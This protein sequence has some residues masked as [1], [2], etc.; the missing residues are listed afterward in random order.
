MRNKLPDMGEGDDSAATEHPET[1][2][3]PGETDRLAARVLWIHAVAVVIALALPLGLTAAD[4][5]PPRLADVL[6]VASLLLPL[7]V[8]EA[9]FVAARKMPEHRPAAVAGFFLGAVFLVAAVPFAAWAVPGYIGLGLLFW[10][11][12]LRRSTLLLGGVVAVIASA[13][14]EVWWQL[15]APASSADYAVPGGPPAG[16]PGLMPALALAVVA[17]LAALAWWTRRKRDRYAS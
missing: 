17:T 10:A 7:A 9:V 8:A 1:Q 11:W 6:Y 2:S 15:S 13:V 12:K 16:T 3:A 5:G 14:P 4:G